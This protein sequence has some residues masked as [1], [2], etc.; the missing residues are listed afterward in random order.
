VT[1]AHLL[2]LVCAATALAVTAA[3]GRAAGLFSL[4]SESESLTAVSSKVFAGYVRAKRADGSYEPETYAFGNGGCLTTLIKADPSIDGIRFDQIARTVAGPL[5]GQDYLPARRPADA[6]LL[7]MIFWGTTF[8]GINT[9]DGALQDQINAA[10]ASLLGFDSER[11]F[12]SAY[13]SSQEGFGT[14]FSDALLRQFHTETLSALEVDRYYVI[15]RAFDFQ[16]AWKQKKLKLLWETRFS[17]SERQ[18]QFDRDLPL[19]T[20]TAAPFFGHDT[21][22]LI[23]SPTAEG[24]V[25]IGDIK[26][27][28]PV[29]DMD[30]K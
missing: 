5:S 19:M 18:H 8:G 20:Q 12:S 29:P 13:R 15:L 14:S 9:Q 27:L 26:S 1:P 22:G 3:N 17:L 6:K 28:G 25:D 10:N 11:I 2:K 30:T 21:N 24:R 23:R 16:K 4:V 7:I